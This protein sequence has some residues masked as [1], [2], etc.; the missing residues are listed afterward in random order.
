MKCK[1]CETDFD[2]GS[3]TPRNLNCGHTFCE[4]C[5]KLYMK[6]EEIECPRCTKKSHY[7]LPICY[8]IFDMIHSEENYKKIEYC[9]S[10]PLEKLQ[11]KCQVD[12]ETICSICL[13]KRHNGHVVVSLKGHTIG[14]AVLTSVSEIKKDMDR[15]RNNLESKKEIFQ[16]FKNEIEKSESLLVCNYREEKKKL[17]EFENQFLNKKKEKLEDFSNLIINNYKKQSVTINNLVSDL[18]SKS[19]ELKYYSSKIDEMLDSL[20]KIKYD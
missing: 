7:K 10:H 8:A 14:K 5:L 13:L 11:F 16:K 3:R 2:T 19:H 1:I 9:L 15:I 20:G 17:S 18:N 12:D 6:G 4:M